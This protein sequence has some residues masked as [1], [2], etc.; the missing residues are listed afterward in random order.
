M[1]QDAETPEATIETLRRRVAEYERWFQQLDSQ[2][3]LLERER[4]KFSAVVTHTDA[5]FVVFDQSMRVDWANDI[6]RT[7]FAGD[8]ATSS[9]SGMPCNR[10]LCRKD[11][12]CDTCPVRTTLDE[13]RISHCEIE[14]TI[15][16]EER[17]VYATAM[18]VKSPEGKIEQSIVMLQ[19]I[20]DLQILRHSE[21]ALRSSEARF[22]SIF[23]A[24]TAGMATVG[25]DGAF[26][27]VNPA[28][29]R[30]LGYEEA[31][32]L[33]LRVQ[34][35]THPEDLPE[36]RLVF[37]E[38]STERPHHVDLEKRYV[39]KGGATVWGRTSAAT[40]LDA[41]GLP[42]Y[43][44]ALVQDISER[45]SLEQDLRQAE[46]MSAVGQLIA[47]VA[48]ELNN[49]LAGVLG[50]SQL[51]LENDVNEKVRRGLD[52]INRE[53][54][55]C[56]RIV[57][58]LQT[59]ARKHKPEVELVGVNGILLS[60][61]EL[62]SYQLRVDDI[63][64]VTELQEDLPETLA[65]AHQLRQV[66]LNIIINAHQAMAAHRGSGTLTLRSRLIGGEVCV[67]IIDDG[68]GIDPSLLGKVFD[69]FFTT[70]DVGQ[71]TG[72]GLSICYG[73]MKEHGGRIS[74][75]NAPG[76][77]A[78]FT[79]NIPVME[80]QEARSRPTPFFEKAA[81]PSAAQARILVVDDEESITDILSQ[82]LG[83]EGH[84]VDLASSGFEALEKIGKASYDLIISDMKM[85]GMGGEELFDRIKAASPVLARR[86]LFSTGDTVSPATT[87]FMERAG[88]RCVQK[89]FDLNEMKEIVEEILSSV[90]A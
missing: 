65:D 20:S 70:K 7:R 8:E 17:H 1:K 60:T 55:R 41:K 23:E 64:I 66:F 89:P 75:G 86:V 24:T 76:G 59:F 47:G 68:P 58:N 28:M 42:E 2:M 49:P 51:L 73:I 9:L 78:L 16:G 36:T 14:L 63:K 3:R 21:E 31:E 30:F 22:R 52:S 50:Y 62:R 85:P 90:A 37:K 81:A 79:I 74:A 84:Q 5:G 80:E 33:R 34:D 13:G 18:P 61:L 39:T 38:D 11:E 15:D 56:K 69:P 10:A 53:A 45:K 4:Q 27:Q 6:F 32:L 67:E 54:D 40:I 19:D 25:I 57:Q 82:I 29:C 87:A 26:I 44:V 35:V 72:L 48:H 83:A 77:G 88:A 12:P 71:G 46:K 43:S